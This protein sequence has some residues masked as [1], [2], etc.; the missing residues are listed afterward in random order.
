[1]CVNIIIFS[2]HR[3]VVV[4]LLTQFSDQFICIVYAYALMF[5]TSHTEWAS[6][7][8]WARRRGW[9]PAVCVPGVCSSVPWE[10]SERWS[11]CCWVSQCSCRRRS[12]ALCCATE[13]LCAPNTNEGTSA[14]ITTAQYPAGPRRGGLKHRAELEKRRWHRGLLSNMCQQDGWNRPAVPEW[15]QEPC[16]WSWQYAS[17][18]GCGQWWTAEMWRR[19]LRQRVKVKKKHEKND[20]TYSHILMLIMMINTL[21]N[22]YKLSNLNHH[23]KDVNTGMWCKTNTSDFFFWKKKNK[24]DFAWCFHFH[25]EALTWLF[26]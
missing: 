16:G 8:Q 14:P 2:M 11:W 18:L 25:M 26:H 15:S 13:W 9:T 3:E 5:P 7:M 17:P 4:W 12:A 1:M 24:F 22:I 10:Q 19:T 20:V 21:F 23:Y 6:M